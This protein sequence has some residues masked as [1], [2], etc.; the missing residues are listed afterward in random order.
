MASFSASGG[1]CFAIEAFP[2]HL[3]FL[4]DL[5]IFTQWGAL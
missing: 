1:Q 5:P 3:Y 2:G 4:H